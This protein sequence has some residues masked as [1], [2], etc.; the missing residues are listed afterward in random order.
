[1]NLKII[2]QLIKNLEA[3]KEELNKDL[4]L[5]Q[6]KTNEIK[7]EAKTVALG[8]LLEN[9]DRREKEIQEERDKTRELDAKIHEWER[10]IKLK[11]REVGGTN[12]GANFAAH[13]KKKEK[14]FENRLDHVICY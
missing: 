7:D 4:K 6:S 11:R 9:K 5:A 10:K 12:A 13:S 3:E 1:M 2:S 8:Q 14:V